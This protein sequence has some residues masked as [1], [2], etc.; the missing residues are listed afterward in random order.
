MYFLK[1]NA[2]ILQSMINNDSVTIFVFVYH[3]LNMSKN[4]SIF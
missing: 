3:Y 1:L 4:I 2:K